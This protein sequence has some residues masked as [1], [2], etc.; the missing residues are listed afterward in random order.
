M[1]EW[2]NAGMMDAHFFSLLAKNPPKIMTW[3][4][5]SS[6]PMTTKKFM[7]DLSVEITRRNDCNDD[8]DC[9]WLLFL[10]LVPAGVCWT[11][12]P[13]TAWWI[14]L[15]FSKKSRR[16]FLWEREVA[17]N[18]RKIKNILLFIIIIIIIILSLLPI[19]AID[20]VVSSRN[21]DTNKNN[22]QKSYLDHKNNN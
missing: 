1:I 3:C 18:K 5:S 9:Y 16:E 22:N 13:Q 20:V 15:N 12:I 19:P 11:Y 17:V 21:N 8:V 2:L 6:Y 4:W 10:L 14:L 7:N